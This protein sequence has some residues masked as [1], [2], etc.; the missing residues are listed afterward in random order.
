MRA[1]TLA[2]V[3]CVLTFGL[4]A[5]GF[6]QVTG[7]SPTCGQVDGKTA[8]DRDNALA[9]CKA[10][11]PEAGVIS[12]ISA[13]KSLLWVKV[14]REI[15]EMMRR[16]RL[17]TEQLVKNWMKAWKHLSGS[18]AVTVYVEWKDVEI[19]KGDTT[20]FSGDKVTIH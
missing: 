4:A 17:T 14:S 18:K 5:S 15:A 19:A 10:G 1:L 6:A 20:L 7:K 8:K 12:S 16:D 2:S 3:V 13:I 9:F 11:V